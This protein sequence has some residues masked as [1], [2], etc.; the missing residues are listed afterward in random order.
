M[1]PQASMQQLWGKIHDSHA[2]FDR[3]AAQRTRKHDQG[4]RN[5]ARFLDILPADPAISP[6]EL[7]ARFVAAPDTP[8]LSLPSLRRYLRRAMA[9]G[10]AL[11]DGRGLYR[12]VT[13]AQ[14]P[15]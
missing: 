4:E 14:D 13:P 7:H 15:Q 9:E 11:R 1:R 12:R 2:R 6:P 5:Y 10:L 3:Y 8:W